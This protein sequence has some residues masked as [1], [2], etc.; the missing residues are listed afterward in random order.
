MRIVQNKG[1]KDEQ[2]RSYKRCELCFSGGTGY[3]F[4]QRY[5]ADNRKNSKSGVGIFETFTAA[6]E[7]L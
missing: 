3:G 4:T 2:L 7:I 1:A 6:S 5:N